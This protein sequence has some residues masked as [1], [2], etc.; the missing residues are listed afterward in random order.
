MNPL[1]HQVVYEEQPES[2]EADVH[3]QRINAVES[4][5]ENGGQCHINIPAMQNGYWIPARSYL[6]FSVTAKLAGV[7]FPEVTDSPFGLKSKAF[8]L[9]SLGAAAFVRRV[10]VLNG[11]G[12]TISVIQDHN[13]LA[14][15][16]R[17]ADTNPSSSNSSRLTQGTSYPDDTDQADFKGTSLNEYGPYTGFSAT[18]GQGVTSP[19][20]AFCLNL[21]GFLASEMPVPLS[22]L[23]DPL[24][25]RLT[26]IGNDQPD[27]CVY[28]AVVPA[29]AEI[30]SMSLTISD[31][32]Y[33]TCIYRLSDA[34][35]AEVREANGGGRMLK[36]SGVDYRTTPIKYTAAQLNSTASIN[37]QVPGFRMRSLR[38]LLSGGFQTEG[39]KAAGIDGARPHLYFDSFRYEIGGQSYPSRDVSS[40]A[41]LVNNTVACFGSAASSVPTTLMRQS[42]TVKN[43]RNAAAAAVTDGAS[44][45]GAFG[46]SFQ[47]FPEAESVSGLMT[48]SANCNL[49]VNTVAQTV[50]ATRSVLQ[51][52][53][54]AYDTICVISEDGIMSQTY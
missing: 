13:R 19:K 1:P 34:A 4:I 47:S 54:G 20:M 17:I 45:R 37:T 2:Y 42:F 14:A 7:G 46:Y 27:L 48:V 11:S 8:R 26:F 16:L 53:V 50:T 22:R 52:V 35:E 33:R 41:D 40:L 43:Y 21:H 32:S 5:V 15:L 39:S 28:T 3:Q 24:Q 29:T 25:I 49:V 38:Y 9:S 10:E 30:T 23:R 18:A 31:I 36:W 6:L 51:Y 12:Q 44:D